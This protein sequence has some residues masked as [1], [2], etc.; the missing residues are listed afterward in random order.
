MIY[1]TDSV[2]INPDVPR[3]RFKYANAF[4]CGGN[5]LM[6][7]GPTKD[8]LIMPIFEERLRQMGQW[9]TINGEA[10]YESVPWKYQNDSLTSFV[11]WVVVENTTRWPFKRTMVASECTRRIFSF[12]YRVRYTSK[13]NQNSGN[14][15]VYC[16]ILHWPK[17]GIVVLGRPVPRDNNTSVTMLGQSG[18]LKW[19][20]GSRPKD[21]MVVYL[22]ASASRSLLWAWVLKFVG[23]I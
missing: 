16:I 17:N 13:V 10:I 23:L 15:T 19:T 6:N 5:L 2:V 9:L 7:I 8:G 1:D 12:V 22:P 20:R 14:T 18:N 4:S 3:V 11:W 21:P